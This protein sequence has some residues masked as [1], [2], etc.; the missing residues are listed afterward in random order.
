MEYDRRTALVVVAA[1]IISGAAASASP[2][3]R[4]WIHPPIHVA[5]PTGR[6]PI[7]P[8]FF[9]YGSRYRYNSPGPVYDRLDYRGPSDS[10]RLWRYNYLYWVC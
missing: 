9:A 4:R 5:T 7:T 3:D 6:S 10:C 1:L 8:Y 2:H